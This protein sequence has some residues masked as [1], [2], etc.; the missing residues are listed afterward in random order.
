VYVKAHPEFY[1]EEDDIVT[2]KRVDVWQVM[3]GSAIAI[4]TVDGKNLTINI[5]RGTQPDTVLSCKG[6]GIPNMRTRVRGNLLVR[7]KVDIPKNLSK[8][9][10]QKIQEIRDGV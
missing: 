7:I 2:E 9:Q 4:S 8:S 3:L 6:E 10:L 1:R 5:P